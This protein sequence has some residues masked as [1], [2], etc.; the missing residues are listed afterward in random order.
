MAALGLAGW[1]P[2]GALSLI[3]V[4]ILLA[5]RGTRL[6]PLFRWLPLPLWCYALPVVAVTLG[7][8]PSEPSDMARYRSLTAWLLPAALALLLLGVDLSA[9]ARSGGRALTAAAAGAMGILL[10]I[11]LVVRLLHHWL[12]PDAWKGAGALAGTWTGGTMNLLA[13]RVILETPEEVFA[14]LI[15]VDAVIAYGWM[16]LLVAASAFQQPINRWLRA[17]ACLETTPTRAITPTA[18]SPRVGAVALCLV[19]A[20][21]VVVG[22]R[23]AADALP[24]SRIVASSTGWT[25]LLVT[26]V[27]L[28]LSLI[29]S[30]RRLGA[31]GDVIGNPC[32]CLVLAATGAQAGLR[33][34][35]SAPAWLVVGVGAVLIHGGIMALVGRWG[36]I[37]L[38]TLATA[39]QANIGGVIS[40]PMVG[41]IYH[42]SL[43]P[44]GLLLAM[45]ANALGT[46]LGW[47]SALLCRWLTG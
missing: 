2:V 44:V 32:L 7:W 36:R 33:A 29:P 23:T 24:A 43:A 18:A 31:C 25:V 42:R 15:V 8:L 39:S 16:A 10:G 37:P 28:G 30:I 17:E 3:V 38:G 27:S 4:G 35:W 34:F 12:P 40:A 13:L 22:A 47:G 19:L 41:A 1:W 5:H 26:T 46:Y 14:P 45:A 9:V 21:G 11:P 6:Q 20:V